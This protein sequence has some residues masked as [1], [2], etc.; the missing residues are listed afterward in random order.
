MG[1]VLLGLLLPTT[2]Q[3]V[4]ADDITGDSGATPVSY[5]SDQKYTVTIP[6]SVDLS[7][8]G[9]E[10]GT[11]TIK[12]G[13][14]LKI[15]PGNV[16]SVA[17]AAGQSR[18]LI[19]AG[20]SEGISYVVKKGSVEV[21][22]DGSRFVQVSA[23]ATGDDVSQALD[24]SA[25]GTPKFSGTYTGTVNFTITVAPEAGEEIT[26]AGA[27]WRILAPD[28]DATVSGYQ[29]LIIKKAALSEKEMSSDGQTGS[30]TAGKKIKFHESQGTYFD[31][32]GDNGYE[33]SLLK[34][35]IDHYYNN[36]IANTPEVAYVNAVSLNNPTLTD[37]NT[38]HNLT[39]T[40]NNGEW[41]KDALHPY[42]TGYARDTNFETTLTTTLKPAGAKQAFALSYG[43]IH[44]NMGLG[45]TALTSIYL[46]FSDNLPADFLLRSVGKSY[47]SPGYVAYYPDPDPDGSWI[48]NEFHMENTAPVRPAL[49][50]TL[51]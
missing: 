30:E 26:F 19:T 12:T 39:W 35:S 11:V 37:Y 3:P 1:L 47:D 5:V 21:A 43:D 15:P 45:G 24:F 48:A 13:E 40:F 16:L 10:T 46:N 31:S 50:V 44:T 38:A 22:N 23:G 32:N 2:L 18:K 33:H 25:S 4:L 8:S 20:D 7:A 17:L 42:S 9:T 14:D 6:L 27:T 49:V 36:F 41:V 28:I 51:Q 29:A 34:S